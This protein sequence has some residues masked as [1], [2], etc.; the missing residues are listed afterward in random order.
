MPKCKM[1]GKILILDTYNRFRDNTYMCSSCHEEFVRKNKINNSV[2][3]LEKSGLLELIDNFLKKYPKKIPEEEI[4]KLNNLL[5]ERYSIEINRGLFYDV[6]LS[7][8]QRIEHLKML[9]EFEKALTNNK[10]NTNNTSLKSMEISS[11]ATL[12]AKALY[13]ALRDRGINCMLEAFDGY[14]HVD[15]SIPE[16]KLYIEIDGLQHSTNSKQLNADLSR[17]FFSKSDGFATK[18]YTNH[19]INNHLDEVVDALFE[20]VQQRK[21][22]IK[23]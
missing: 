10:K 4:N 15:I 12:Q 13:Y 11:K 7:A 16:A 14:K 22:L 20:V 18:H 9:D 3:E 21:K 5:I 8:K 17:D 23:S 19:E 6:L 2:S 1:C